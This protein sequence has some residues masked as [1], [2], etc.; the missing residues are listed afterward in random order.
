MKTGQQEGRG[1]K[2]AKD[3]S[4]G[5]ARQLE[6]EVESV[7]RQERQLKEDWTLRVTELERTVQEKRLLI[8]NLIENLSMVN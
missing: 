5:A 1:L 4:E 2:A 7:Q 6:R 8:H 3:R